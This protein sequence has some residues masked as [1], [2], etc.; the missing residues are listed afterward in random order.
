MSSAKNSFL[1]LIKGRMKLKGFW[2]MGEL[3]FLV[4]QMNQTQVR[5]LSPEVKKDAKEFLLL[6]QKVGKG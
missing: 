2:T 4:T 1:F 6:D 3:K 5:E